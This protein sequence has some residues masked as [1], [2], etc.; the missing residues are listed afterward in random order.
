MAEEIRLLQEPAFDSLEGQKFFLF[1][2]ASR[3]MSL[4]GLQFNVTAVG[5]GIK[6][7][8]TESVH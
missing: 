1:S 7:P 6:R 2:K 4:Y 3:P 5:L 8:E